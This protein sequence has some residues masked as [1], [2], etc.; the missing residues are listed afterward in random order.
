MR[1]VVV[2]FDE[3]RGWGAVRD[4]A[5]EELFFHCTA[6]ADASRTI[7]EGTR[8]DYEVVPGHRGRWEAWSLT[9]A[10]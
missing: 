9:S 6:I 7:T 10:T 2:D 8:V 5:G 1:G 3:R 4:D